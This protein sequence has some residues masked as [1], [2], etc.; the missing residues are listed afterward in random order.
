MFLVLRM[1]DSSPLFRGHVPQLNPVPALQGQG[2]AIGA[3]QTRPDDVG[4][5]QEGDWLPI[6]AGVPQLHAAPIY[7][8][9]GLAVGAEGNRIDQGVGVLWSAQFLPREYVPQPDLLSYSRR[10]ELPIGTERQTANIS[11]LPL[12]SGFHLPGHRVPEFDWMPLDP[13]GQGL[14]VRAECQGTDK[15]PRVFHCVKLL[16]GRRVPQV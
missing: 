15:N 13:G 9:Q 1:E 7:P 8:Y 14:A 16:A 5:F 10:Q 11:G 12:E 4:L 6:R 2:P 3:E